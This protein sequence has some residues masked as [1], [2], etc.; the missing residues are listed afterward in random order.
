MLFLMLVPFSCY[1][2]AL[3]LLQKEWGLDNAAGA[4]VFSSYLVGAALSSLLVVPLADRFPL[5]R[6][7]VGSV[8]VSVGSHLLFPLI[9]G[10]VVVAALLRLL[11]GAGHAAAYVLGIRLVFERV[12]AAYRGRAVGLFVSFGFAGTTLSYLFMG[13]ALAWLDS[14]RSAY[15]ALALAAVP[16]IVLVLLLTRGIGG[17]K[18][19]GEGRRGFVELAVLRQPRL[20]LLTVAYALHAAELYV[21]RL[22][23]PLLLAAAFVAA[24]TPSNEAVSQGARLAG[25]MFTLGVPAVLFGGAVSDRLGRARSAAL[26]FAVSGL[27]SL[28]AGWLV[29]FPSLL[30]ALG[31]LYGFATAAD[32]A[33]YSTAVVELAPPDAVGSAQAVQSFIGFLVAAAAPVVAGHIL[34]ATRSLAGWAFAFGFNACLAIPAIV[35][36]AW[37]RRSSPAIG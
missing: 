8:V 13:Q 28:A 34:D 6:L 15:L 24:G 35:C 11:A 12:G 23:F 14:W 21:A 9:A 29:P 4:A 3:P 2:V 10:G 31:F 18:H 20:F 16:S 26:I 32:S 1:V 22:W 7:I 17:R 33:I 19:G 30:V 5:R 36:L 27:T 37:L 25:L